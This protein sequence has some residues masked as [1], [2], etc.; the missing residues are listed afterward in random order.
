MKKL[1][2][3]GV[4]LVIKYRTNKSIST[5]DFDAMI[6]EIDSNATGICVQESEELFS[7]NPDSLI[8]FLHVVVKKGEGKIQ[9]NLED[10]S[11]FG[12]LTSNE[13]F[14]NGEIKG[15]EAAYF[16][17]ACYTGSICWTTVHSD[18]CHDTVDKLCE[19]IMRAT[20][21]DRKFVM[22]MLL[23]LETIVYIADYKVVEVLEID[24]WDE[25]NEK[26]IYRQIYKA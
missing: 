2:I 12:L 26:I 20:G 10:L 6:D 7:S 15:N 22:K 17:N 4:N 1:G 9:Y 23:A 14:F 11:K 8:T 18:S 24:R 19:Y 21:Y 3:N 13:Y 25:A 5:M 16:A